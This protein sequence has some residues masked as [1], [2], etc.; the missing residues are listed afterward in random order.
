MSNKKYKITIVVLIVIILLLLLFICFKDFILTKDDHKDIVNIFEIKCDYNC[1]VNSKQDTDINNN[2]KRDDIN[3]SN[4]NKTSASV[5]K[6]ENSKINNFD[7]IDN[8]DNNSNTEYSDA[9]EIYDNNV[10][11]RSSDDLKIFANSTYKNSNIIAPGITGK[12]K[13]VVSNKTRFN[14]KYVM[15]FEETN[16]YS[17]NMKYRLLNGNDYIVSDWS[18]YTSLSQ[19]DVNL[20]SGNDNTYYLEWKWFDSSNDTSIGSSG[21]ANYK[22]KINIKAEQIND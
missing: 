10:S 5:G 21:V 14:I 6:Y 17:I 7:N 4:N 3:N 18:D 15:L 8:T 19:N 16:D 11:W 2:I 22:L 1:K 9:I 12:Y 20:L 13:F